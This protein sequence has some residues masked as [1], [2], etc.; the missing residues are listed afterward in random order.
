[1]HPLSPLGSLPWRMFGPSRR[2]IVPPPPP[3]EKQPGY[4]PVGVA[5]IFAHT[6]LHTLEIL[7]EKKKV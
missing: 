1:M 2:W 5:K 7:K 3:P 6:Q 4:G